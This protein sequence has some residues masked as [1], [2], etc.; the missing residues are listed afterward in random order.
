MIFSE[1]FA[2][3]LPPGLVREARC[4]L[5]FVCAAQRC[6]VAELRRFGWMRR[7]ARGGSGGAMGIGQEGWGCQATWN[8]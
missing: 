3:A 7:K 5:V 6:S 8:H 1:P 4:M 2:V